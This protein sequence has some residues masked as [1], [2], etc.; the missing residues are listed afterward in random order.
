MVWFRA[1]LLLSWSTVNTFTHS[2]RCVPLTS[3]SRSY[4]VDSPNS[5]FTSLTSMP[6]FSTAAANLWTL[7]FSPG[8]RGGCSPLPFSVRLSTSLREPPNLCLSSSDRIYHDHKVFVLKTLDFKTGPEYVPRGQLLA[9]RQGW[10][11]S[12][13]LAQPIPVPSAWQCWVIKASNPLSHGIAD[14]SQCEKS[15]KVGLDT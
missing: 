1:G 9:D 8:L 14:L 11:E 7:G 15:Q 6:D 10:R 5:T 3:F 2:Q 4:Q 12:F 13:W